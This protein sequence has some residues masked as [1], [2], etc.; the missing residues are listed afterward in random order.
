MRV[1]TDATKVFPTAAPAYKRSNQYHAFAMRL[2]PDRKRVLYTRPVPG[3][4][5]SD[6][7][8][9]SGRY[10]IVLRE[11]GGG[12]ETVLP[13]EPLKEGWQSVP[14][15]FNIFDPAGAHLVLPNFKVETQQ[16][17]EHTSRS[18]RKNSSRPASVI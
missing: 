4:E 2:S 13:V 12:K 6:E 1:T 15:R 9:R 14:T 8:D 16:I 17:D 7:A 5:P 3:T 10:E 11:L 18:N